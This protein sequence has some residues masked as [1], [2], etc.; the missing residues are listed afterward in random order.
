MKVLNYTQREEMKIYGDG[1][2]ILVQ[3]A[4]W[5]RFIEPFVKQ[6]HKFPDFITYK[7]WLVEF[8]GWSYGKIDEAYPVKY[9]AVYYPMN[10]YYESLKKKPNL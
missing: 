5:Q 10:D 3:Y 8:P 7:N 1:Y 6:E 4:H 9:E 2:D